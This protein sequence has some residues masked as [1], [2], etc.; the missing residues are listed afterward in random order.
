MTDL[1]DVRQE[2]GKKEL[3]LDDLQ[4]DPYKQFDA[5]YQARQRNGIADAN[6]MVLATTDSNG[7]PSQR[8]VLLKYFDA[9]G[10]VFFTNYNSRKGA[11]LAENNAASLLF[12]WRSQEQ[13]IRIEGRVQKIAAADSDAYFNSRDKLARIGAIASH[14]SQVIKDKAALIDEVERLQ[15][16]YKGQEHI[17]CPDYWGGYCLQAHAF[18]FWQGGKHRLHDRF[19]YT[20]LDDSWKIERLAP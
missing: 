9:N 3:R 17:T 14:Q 16:K 7:Q 8:I 20:R 15:S 18:E 2:Y 5:W 11:E 1:S 4:S 12:W 10:F 13:Q 19:R 6:A